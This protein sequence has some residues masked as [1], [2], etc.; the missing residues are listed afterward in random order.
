MLVTVP[1]A[2]L[3]GI[4]GRPV[5]VEV[6][7]GTGL[8]GFTV[9]GLPDTGCREARDRVRAALLT[10]GFAWPQGRITVNL[11]PPGLRKLGAGLDLAMAVGLLAADGQLDPDRIA[12]RG[13]LGELGL[14]GSLRPTP[15]VLPLVEAVTTPEVIVPMASAIEALAAG[16]RRVLPA[17]DLRELVAALSGRGPW[18]R[19]P[20]PSAFEPVDEEPPVSSAGVGRSSAVRRAAMV[21]AAG[22]HHLLLV[23]H[24]APAAAALARWLAGLL[25]DL[26][27]DHALEVTR[28]HSAAGLSLPPGGLVRRPPLRHPH[29]SASAVSVI[30]GGSS[31]VR[32]GE[33]SMAHRGVLLLDELPELSPAVLDSLRQPM[34][35]GAIRVSRAAASVVLP[36]RFQ[37]IAAMERCPCGA[38]EQPACRCSKHALA[39][40]AR[41]VS[42]PFLD[43]FDLMLDPYRPVP[44][45]V[46]ELSAA[47]PTAAVTQLV[48]AARRRAHARGVAA[49]VDLDAAQLDEMA[50][51]SPEARSHLDRAVRSGRLTGRGY[52]AVRRVALTVADLVGAEPPL[53]REHVALA[54][55]LRAAGPWGDPT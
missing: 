10:S 22:G 31:E 1:A 14:D 2:T 41:R 36:A 21:A 30:G 55:D 4:D 35:T 12:H 15:G 23:G 34:E 51:L 29:W 9:V 39:R 47:R 19:P 42:G 52:Q 11:V 37:L 6:H 17:S 26:A 44:G 46:G 54:L 40:Y 49:N 3:A 50:P 24:R 27:D 53:G 48:A 7:V 18:P 45:I 20:E 32:P 8:P 33:I 5:Q 13:F 25:P 38:D 16:G 28:V 43:R